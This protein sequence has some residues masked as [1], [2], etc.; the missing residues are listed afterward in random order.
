MIKHKQKEVLFMTTDIALLS[1]YLRNPW[2][3]RDTMY[4]N[5]PCWTNFT[6]IFH[7]TNTMV[8]IDSKYEN[9]RKILH[10]LI[11]KCYETGFIYCTA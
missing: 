1:N 5:I 8:H 2:F 9:Q 11:I 7:R 10:D 3:E 6:Y 4:K